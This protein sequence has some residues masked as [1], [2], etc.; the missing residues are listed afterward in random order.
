MGEKINESVTVL[1][2][3]FS[4]FNEVIPAGESKK[5]VL[6]FELDNELADSINSL[7]LI[8]KDK[9]NSDTVSLQ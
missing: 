8:I 9:N 1:M 6:I 7:D 3:S 4:Q 2:D 5:A